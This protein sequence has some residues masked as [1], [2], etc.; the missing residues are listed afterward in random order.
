MIYI[1]GGK[2][3][4][5]SA[6]ER[7]FSTLGE[8]FKVITKYNFEN[9]RGSSCDFLINANGN[10]K[11]YLSDKEPLLDFDLSVRSVVNS[12]EAFN[13]KMYILL[14]SGD[15]Y[16]DTSHSELT[17]EDSFIDPEKLSRYGLHKYLAEMIVRGTH[18]KYLIIRMGGFVGPEIKKNAI[19]DMLTNSP[20]WLSPESQLQFISTDTAASLVWALVKN[21][22]F[23]QVVNIGGVGLIKLGDFHKKIGS[24]SIFNPGSP[25]I[26]YDLKIEKIKSLL[27]MNLPKSEDEVYNFVSKWEKN[28]NINFGS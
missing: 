2:G 19:F 16:P 7:L 13:S 27:G 20:V 9:F 10:S 8:E 18:K 21:N 15:V 6:Y 1:L 23:N 17:D 26:R 4:V 5:G 12:L 24:K 3:F 22:I 14:S 28:I 25:K 11:K